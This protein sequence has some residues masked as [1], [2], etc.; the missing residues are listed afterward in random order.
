[1]GSTVSIHKRTAQTPGPPVRRPSWAAAL[2]R[3]APKWRG[4]QAQEPKGKE[5]PAAP[6]HT[7]RA[8]TKP[9]RHQPRPYALTK[10]MPSSLSA[11]H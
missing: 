7:D 6:V 8:N 1:M 3:A 2:Q 9:A 5:V 4:A 10:L 11:A